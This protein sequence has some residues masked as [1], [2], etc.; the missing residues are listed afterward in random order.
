MTTLEKFRKAD[1]RVTEI[2]NKLPYK[3]EYC[4]VVMIVKEYEDA[5]ELARTLYNELEKQGINPF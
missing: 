2:E 5:L 1:L 4:D 3:A